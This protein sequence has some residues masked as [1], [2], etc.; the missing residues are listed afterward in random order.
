MSFT[1]KN[2]ERRHPACWSDCPDYLRDK[3]RTDEVRARRRD[4][5]RK[6]NDIICV[7][8]GRGTRR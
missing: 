8:A 7:F 4:V 5:R 1:C 3:Q 6:E 2:C